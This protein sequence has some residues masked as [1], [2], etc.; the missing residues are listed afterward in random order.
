MRVTFLLLGRR[1]DHDDR[2]EK[3]RG[4]QEMKQR[5]WTEHRSVGLEEFPHEPL[6]AIKAG[7]EIE[8]LL[9][10]EAI[11]PQHAPDVDQRERRHGG[12]FVKLHRMARQTVAEVMR[13]GK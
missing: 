5:E 3:D 11:A 9:D 8:A 6:R 2:V 4:G 10:K 13:P 7:G 12:A 1:C